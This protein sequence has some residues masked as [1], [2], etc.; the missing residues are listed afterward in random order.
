MHFVSAEPAFELRSASAADRL[1]LLRML[2]LYQHDLSDVWDQDLDA[3][4][5]Y[6]YALDEYWSRPDC[7]PFVI[8]VASRYAG[9]ALVTNRVK[10]A[11][12]SYWLEQY[13]IVKKYRRAGIG[14]AAAI[15]L[16][17][18]LPGLWQ[19]GQMPRNH[20]AQAFWRKVVAN[21]TDGAYTET[22]LSHGS[23]QGVLQQFSTRARP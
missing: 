10:L 13:F 3:H 17:D 14:M 19:V 23:W 11:G 20:A 2:E 8:L 5:E 21:Y 1:P 16:F 4:G 15:A 12:G 6:G 22:Q 7:K 18:A 9:F